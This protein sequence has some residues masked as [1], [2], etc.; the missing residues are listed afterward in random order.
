MTKISPLELLEYEK[1]AAMFW[2][3]QLVGCQSLSIE[4]TVAHI[5]TMLEVCKN[6][7]EPPKGFT[8]AEWEAEVIRRFQFIE[9]TGLHIVQKLTS[10]AP[11]SQ[12]H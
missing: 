5:H 1:H 11:T 12:L 3:D 4:A 2:L 6:L 7:D 9:A 8:H 10:Q